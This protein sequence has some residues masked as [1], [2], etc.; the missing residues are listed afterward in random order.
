MC[1]TLLYDNMYE[2]KCLVM[3]YQNHTNQV[4]TQHLQQLHSL[5]PDTTS[6]RWTQY[7]QL[8]RQHHMI[9]NNTI[10]NGKSLGPFVSKL[11]RPFVEHWM[12]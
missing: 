1:L 7:Q 12:G 5:A 4:A 10:S 11:I 3:D 8:W 2:A 6:A 9:I